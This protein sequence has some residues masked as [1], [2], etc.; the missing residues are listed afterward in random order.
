MGF[1]HSNLSSSNSSLWEDETFTVLYQ[2]VQLEV[3]GQGIVADEPIQAGQWIWTSHNMDRLLDAPSYQQ[4]LRSV[5]VDLVCDVIRWAY[6][7]DMGQ[8]Y[9]EDLL[10]SVDLDDRFYCNGAYRG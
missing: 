4:F 9:E 1:K 6:V 5:P 10:I 8:W 2:T 3:K 7:Q